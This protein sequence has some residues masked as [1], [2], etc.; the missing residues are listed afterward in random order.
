MSARAATSR[1]G[2]RGAP[3]RSRVPRSLREPEMVAAARRIFGDRG[4]ASASMDDIA[5]AA[6]V[7]KPLLYAYFGSKEDLFA[8]CVKEAGREFRASVAAAAGPVDGLAPDQR[9]YAGLLAVFAGIERDRQAWDLL[10]PLEG[11]GPGGALG[12]RASYGV[13]AMTEMV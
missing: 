6:G 12:A 2:R 8:A 1:A 13:T 11:E 9:L 7:S 5:S 4:Y 3:G 10:Y